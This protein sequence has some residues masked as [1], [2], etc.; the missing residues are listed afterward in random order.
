MPD[1]YI[2][3]FKGPL[4]QFPRDPEVPEHVAV[5]GDS[6]GG[7]T[8]LMA[9]LTIGDY[10]D[11]G[12]YGDVSSAVNCIVDWYG[13]TDII[14]M[15][16]YPSAM[17]HAEPASP[18]GRLIGFKNVR[19]EAELSRKASPLYYVSAEKATPPLLIMHGNRDELV[20]YQQSVAL[21]KKMKAL[22]KDVR[23]ICLDGAYHGHGGFQCDEALAMVDLF[24]REKL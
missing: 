18:E 12:T 9:G 14:E 10:P 21:Y 7:H 11:N 24:L 19:E 8:A 16:S 22:G 17:D 15:N 6:S 5:W 1:T 2:E 3:P 20:C 23:M 13:P 4:S